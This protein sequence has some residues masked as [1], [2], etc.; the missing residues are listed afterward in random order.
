MSLRFGGRLPEFA[1]TLTAS[2]P[3]V[4]APLDAGRSDVVCKSPKKPFD[5]SERR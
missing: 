3:L 4:N 1:E 5:F 2:L